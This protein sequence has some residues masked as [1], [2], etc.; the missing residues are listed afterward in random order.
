MGRGRH[1]YRHTARVGR[2]KELP[3][4]SDGVSGLEWVGLS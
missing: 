4:G 1:S 2:K 3:C